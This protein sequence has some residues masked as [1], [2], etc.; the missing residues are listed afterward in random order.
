VIDRFAPLSLLSVLPSAKL[1]PRHTLTRLYL[2]RVES[3]SLGS[4]GTL[5]KLHT[6][7]TTCLFE[8]APAPIT[9]LDA[10][11]DIVL[12]LWDAQELEKEYWRFDNEIPAPGQRFIF[13]V[14]LALSL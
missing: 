6:D 10:G 13:Y 11:L 5:V 4:L 3:L 9:E 1:K 14:N 2:A 8:M 7:I 12:P